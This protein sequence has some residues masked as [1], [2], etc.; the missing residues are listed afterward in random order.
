MGK[1]LSDMTLEELWELF[2]IFLVKHDD[3]WRQQYE[4]VEEHLVELLSDRSVERI[5][6]IGSTA[7]DGIWAKDI[8][9]VMVELSTQ[10]ELEKA[11]EKLE[12]SGFTMMSDEGERVSL[13]LGYTKDGF[14]EKV[15]H[16]HLRLV[17]DNDELYFRDYLNAH[18]QTAREY[19]ALKLRLWKEFEHD[20]N[21]YTEAKTEFIQGVTAQARQEYAGR[22]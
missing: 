10:A 2:P 1:E 9:D 19:E 11:A 22:Y 4:E 17:G 20:R 21:A 6:H 14:A 13:N 7:V 16:V 12:H 8:V 15:Y 18:P 5:S 3:T